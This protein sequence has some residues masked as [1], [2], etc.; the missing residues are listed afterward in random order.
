MADARFHDWSK[1]VSILAM[2]PNCRDEGLTRMRGD[3]TFAQ[4]GG[5][6]GKFDRRQLDKFQF[7]L[8][9]DMEFRKDTEGEG[10]KAEWL[11]MMR[12]KRTEQIK[13]ENEQRKAASDAGQEAM[14]L[15]NAGLGGR[16]AT[17]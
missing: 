4:C 17:T 10:P 12:K 11:R 13:T 1:I 2:C 7:Q 5:C 3:T 6:G 16:T 15:K 9:T 14:R 8:L